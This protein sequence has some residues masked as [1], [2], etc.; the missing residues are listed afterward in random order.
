MK[1]SYGFDSLAGFDLLDRCFDMSTD[2]VVDHS[3][4]EKPHFGHGVVVHCGAGIRCCRDQNQLMWLRA[5]SSSLVHV[6]V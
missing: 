3:V 4:Y 6:E 1:G 2:G 5:T